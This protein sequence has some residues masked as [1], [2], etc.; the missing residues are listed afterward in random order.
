V[1]KLG[2][3]VGATSCCWFEGRDRA[4]AGTLVS[5]LLEGA[6]KPAVIRRSG[7]SVRASMIGCTDGRKGVNVEESPS[8]K[9]MAGFYSR[10][11]S[12]GGRVLDVLL[13]GHL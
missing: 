6:A 1:T 12:C 7:R 2:A 5:S 4:E 8:I 3:L 10:Y 13:M 11:A 9:V